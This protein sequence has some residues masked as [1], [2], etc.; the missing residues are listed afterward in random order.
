MASF[1]RRISQQ[2]LPSP[3]SRAERPL[4]HQRPD[5]LHHLGDREQAL[6][7]GQVDAELVHEVA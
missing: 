4:V 5:A 7:A 3:A 1:S 2:Q 6:H